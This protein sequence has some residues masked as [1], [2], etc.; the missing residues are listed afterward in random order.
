M[1]TQTEEIILGHIIEGTVLGYRMDRET[2]SYYDPNAA[3]ARVRPT[4][5][6]TYT[7]TLVDEKGNSFD[8]DVTS[9]FMGQLEKSAAAGNQRMKFKMEIKLID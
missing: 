9:Q 2:T 4:G 6:I 8:L 3:Y 1:Q 5:R 7:A